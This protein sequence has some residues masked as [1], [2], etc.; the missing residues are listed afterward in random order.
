ML[1]AGLMEARIRLELPS[2]VSDGSTHQL[3]ADCSREALPFGSAE[4]GFKGPRMFVAAQLAQWTWEN[5]AAA[6]LGATRDVTRAMFGVA[7]T[8]LSQ[9]TALRDMCGL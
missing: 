8:A 2:P 6:W 3:C 9:L 4:S 7:G 5:E 1:L